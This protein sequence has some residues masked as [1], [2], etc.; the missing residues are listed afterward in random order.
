MNAYYFTGPS[1]WTGAQII[2]VAETEEQA[3][4]LAREEYAKHGLAFRE[5]HKRINPDDLTLV[6]AIALD[7]AKVLYFENGDC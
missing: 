3:A 1:G 5:N 4:E 2:V 7:C 6:S